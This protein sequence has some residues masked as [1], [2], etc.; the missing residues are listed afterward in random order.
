MDI[1]RNRLRGG[2]ALSAGNAE[3]VT[4]ESI[5]AAMTGAWH[6]LARAASEPN[7]FYEHWFLKPALAHLG[8]SSNLRL[9]LLWAGESGRSELL[10]LLPIGPTAKFGRWPVPHI[11]NWVHPNCFLGTPLVRAGHE[12]EFWEALFTTLGETRWPGFLHING[13]TIG[14]PLDRALRSVCEHQRRRCDLVQSEARAILQS[15]LDPASYYEQTVRSKKRKELRRQA[16]RLG[17]EG[18]LVYRRYADDEAIGEWTEEF[19][20]LERHGW[21]GTNGSALDCHEPTRNFFRALL[22]SAAKAGQLERLDIRLDGRPLAMLINFMS[23]PGSFSFKTA[24][25]EDFARFSPG[26]LLQ[27]ENL[28]ILDNPAVAWMDSCAA[29]DHPMIDSLWSGRRHVGRFSIE[30]RGLSRF[31]IFRGVRLGEDLM[32][33]IKGREII[34][35]MRDEK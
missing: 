24:F 11:Q 29:E 30:L 19:L 5:D 13:L 12:E 15:D 6:E 17:E 33:Q 14:G 9:F 10:G 23:P 31:A 7:C 26:V 34:D 3:L 2:I 20:Q 27:L 28:K 4:A 8:I 32:A 16:K 18:Q 25:D 1:R 35:I 22:P 21:K